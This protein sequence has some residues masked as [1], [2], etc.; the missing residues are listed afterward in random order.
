M[1]LYYA[2][3]KVEKLCTDRKTIEKKFRGNND[4]IEGIVY[5]IFQLESAITLLDIKR[6]RDANLHSLEGGRRYEL[7]V[8]ALLG[9]KRW[10]WRIIFKQRNGENICD[11]MYNDAKYMTITEIE[12]LEIS[13]HYKK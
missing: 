7:A 13:D 6:T 2:S 4:L 12:I 8:D 11:D 3:A 10:T 9:W 1:K 5:R